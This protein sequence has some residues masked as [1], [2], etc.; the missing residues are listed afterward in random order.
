[1][2]EPALEQDPHARTGRLRKA[3]NVFVALAA[4]VAADWVW[5][6]VEYDRLLDR[7]ETSEAAIHE[8]TADLERVSAPYV[9]RQRRALSNSEREAWRRQYQ[10]S[11]GKSASAILVAEAGVA[12]VFV[13]P[14][15]RSIHKAKRLYLDHSQAWSN[16]M[17]EVSRDSDNSDVERPEIA[18]TF[19]LSERGLRSALPWG[20]IRSLKF[21]SRL[22]KIF[23]D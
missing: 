19:V 14:W 11:A 10:E 21:Q 8:S 7:V 4:L 23:E 9:E 3:V 22:D 1:M 2:T 15:H 6:H 5:R 13:L 16:F 18:A 17:T 20:P 12:D